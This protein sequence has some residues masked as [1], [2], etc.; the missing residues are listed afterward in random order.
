MS[1]WNVHQGV[2]CVEC[3]G[4]AFTFDADHQDV[5]RDGYTCPE[6]GTTGPP[7]DTTFARPRDPQGTDWVRRMKSQRPAS[8]AAWFRMARRGRIWWP[9]KTFTIDLKEMDDA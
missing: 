8:I 5:D 2:T 6:C 3:P 1:E 9:G 7:V 4:C